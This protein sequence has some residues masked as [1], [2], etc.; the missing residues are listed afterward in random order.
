MFSSSLFSWVNKLLTSPFML[1]KCFFA[2][3]HLFIVPSKFDTLSSSVTSLIY[4]TGFPPHNWP[5][6]ISLLGGIN[7]LGTMT[8]PFSIF[9]PSKITVFDPMYAS[10]SIILEYIVQLFPI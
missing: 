7:E 2:C 9:D 4:W 10:S 1:S 6:G 8:A 5:P 3:S